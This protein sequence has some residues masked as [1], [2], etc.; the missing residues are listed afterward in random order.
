MQKRCF[1]NLYVLALAN[2]NC[3]AMIRVIRFSIK[4]MF[5]LKTTLLSASEASFDV[6]ILQL[7]STMLEKSKNYKKSRFRTWG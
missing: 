6:T 3:K 7:Q 4:T 5:L 1:L 2:S